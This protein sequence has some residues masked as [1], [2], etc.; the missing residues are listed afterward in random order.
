MV[1]ALAGTID[2]LP[3]DQPRYV[4]GLGDPVGLVEAVHLGVDMFDCVLPTR[5]GRHGTILTSQGRLNLRNARY[6]DDDGPLDPDFDGDGTGRYSRAYLRHLLMTDEPTAARLLT[7]HN[8]TWT[9]DLVDRMRSS[10]AA[11][12]FA[13]LRRQVL[14]VW[15]GR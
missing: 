10:I 12:T 7:L 6:A 14:D 3:A 1:E 11:G 5:L 9:L 4:M 8:V 15:G 13:A 2:R